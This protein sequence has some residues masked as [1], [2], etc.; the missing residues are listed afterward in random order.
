MPSLIQT[1]PSKP[2]PPHQKAQEVVWL[3]SPLTFEVKKRFVVQ[4]ERDKFWCEQ[5]DTLYRGDVLYHTKRDAL[6]AALA[7]CRKSIFDLSTMRDLLVAQ[8]VLERQ[9]RRVR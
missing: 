9:V 3:F 4:H 6:Q 1:V 2:K 7:M 8:L 5:D